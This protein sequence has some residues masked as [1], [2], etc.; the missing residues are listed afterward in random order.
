MV[1]AL[2]QRAAGAALLVS[3]LGLVPAGSVLADAEL[4]E[5]V[6]RLRAEVAELRSEQREDWMTERRAEEVKALINEVLADADTRS[7][8]HGGGVT[9]GHDGK[10]FIASADGNY[11]LNVGAFLQTRYI[12]NINGSDPDNTGP[13]G[14]FDTSGSGNITNDGQGFQLARTELTFSGHAVVPELGY[15]VVLSGDRDGDGS[16]FSDDAYVSYDFHKFVKGLKVKVGHQKLPFT[17]QTLIS[18]GYQLAVDRSSVD[19]LFTLKRQVGVDIGYKTDAYKL[20]FQ[21][22]NGANT[23]I[24]DFNGDDAGND[25][26]Y[27]LT[28]RGDWNVFKSDWKQ[29]KDAIAW[30]GKPTALFIGGA[31][32]WQEGGSETDDG[33]PFGDEYLGWTV[34]GIYKT[35]PFSVQA[36][37]MQGLL[38][39]EDQKDTTPWGV[40]AEAGYMLSPDKIQPFVR[41]EAFDTNLKGGATN[42]LATAGFNWFIKKHNLK[43][44]ADAV[45]VVHGEELKKFAPFGSDPFS[46]GL[47]FTDGE[48][49]GGTSGDG[50]VV[51]RTQLQVLF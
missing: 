13:D 45:W 43:F 51:L 30:S 24:S 34:D 49:G 31:V 6:A 14:T 39:A 21:V 44:T 19:S 33:F 1:Q 27:A 10:F 29:S 12:L 40:L 4:G 11:R 35:G 32:H 37:Y 5:E 41:Y 47:G 48:G 22:G 9:A 8:L 17:R 23:N 25:A 46:D 18:D 42:H 15:K 36:A 7:S 26:D 3:T 50:Q 16:A 28:L 38:H 20:N 2:T